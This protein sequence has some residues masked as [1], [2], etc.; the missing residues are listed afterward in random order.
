[1]LSDQDRAKALECLLEAHRTK[2]PCLQL[3]KIFPNIEI[4]DSYAISSAMADAMIAKGRRLIGHKIGLTSKA[5]QASSQIDEPDYG[6]LFDNML[7]ENG[8]VLDH[9]EFCVPR[10]EPELTFVLKSPL[11][12]PGVGLVDVMRA[13]EYV[14]PSIEVIDARVQNPRQICDTVAD[15]GAAAALILGG[16]PV[17]PDDIDLRWVGCIFHRNSDIEETGIAA[18]VLGHPAMAI[19]WLANKLARFDVTL[20]P[21]HLMLSGSFT[22]P[23]WAENGDTLHADFGPLGSVSV[24]FR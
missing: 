19:A 9:G 14:I 21:G 7:Y 15:N 4:E 10:V 23:V 5:M 20:E 12:G 6:Y 1:M 3:T 22:R 2:T 17:R 13:T 11:R 18:G 16:N 8:V 24:T